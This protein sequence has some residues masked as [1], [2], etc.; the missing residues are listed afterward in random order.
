[1]RM[2]LHTSY[3]KIR[4]MELIRSPHSNHW[5]AA[6]ICLKRQC[7]PVDACA[8]SARQSIA[9]RCDLHTLHP[10]E[11]ENSPMSQPQILFHS[12]LAELGHFAGYTMA[13]TFISSTIPNPHPCRWAPLILPLGARSSYVDL[14]LISSALALSGARLSRSLSACLGSEMGTL[15]WWVHG[16]CT[17]RFVGSWI[18]VCR[19]FCTG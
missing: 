17:G 12:S 6:A 4:E 15:G 3:P 11:P 2:L 14:R 7:F 9:A 16:N 18:L 10:R 8:R 19:Q 5:S 13:S 1:M